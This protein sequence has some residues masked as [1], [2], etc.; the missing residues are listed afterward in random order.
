MSA[1][2][3]SRTKPL[4]IEQEK[5]VRVYYESNV[6]NVCKKFPL[7]RKVQVCEPFS[8]YFKC[9]FEALCANEMIG[10]TL[11]SMVN[12]LKWFMIHR[13]RPLYFLKDSI[14]DGRWWN[15]SQSI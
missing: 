14:C 4:S 15:I 1:E 6:H 13:Q 7:P 12:L 2:K 5:C 3:H 10:A 11:F 8:I 9:N